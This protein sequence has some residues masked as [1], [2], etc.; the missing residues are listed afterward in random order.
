MMKNSL[1]L[2]FIF[3]I[4]LPLNPNGVDATNTREFEDTYLEIGY[5][6][7]EEALDEFEKH[8]NE[9]LLLPL[10][11]PP[12]GFTHVFGRFNDLEGDINDSFEVEFINEAIGKNHYMINVKHI[13]QKLKIPSKYVVKTYRL[14]NGNVAH[15]L[16]FESN[17]DA[18]VFEIGP[19]QYR[20]SIPRRL[21]EE[22]TVEMLVD[23]ANSIE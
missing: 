20:L 17:F 12:I 5:K 16:D 10:R 4:L 15:H 13:D 19:W 1:I 21:S 18:L 22:V 6:S 23:I 8:Y 11:V 3:L 9:E 7:V 14:Q 2:T